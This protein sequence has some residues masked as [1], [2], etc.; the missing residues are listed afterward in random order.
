MLKANVGGIDRILRIV[1][2]LGM[3][4]GAIVTGIS[5]P[6]LGIIVL[7]TGLFQFCGAYTIFGINTCKLKEPSKTE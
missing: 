5:W 3:I 2:G 1:V 6:Y 4:I 7:G